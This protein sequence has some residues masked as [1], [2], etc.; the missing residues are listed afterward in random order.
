MSFWFIEHGNTNQRFTCI[1][2]ALEIEELGTR[3]L[4]EAMF[5][6]RSRINCRA[7]DHRSTRST[8]NN[9]S[10]VITCIYL[11]IGRP[12]SLK[13]DMPI[14]FYFP[15]HSKSSTPCI[16]FAPRLLR[17]YYVSIDA[18][19]K[20]NRIWTSSRAPCSTR[21]IY[22]FRLKF[23]NRQATS[24]GVNQSSQSFQSSLT[25]FSGKMISLTAPTKNDW[26]QSS[27]MN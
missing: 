7:G 5:E 13:I 16:F 10:N 8:G 22:I 1:S 17:W 21:L 27:E 6:N 3:G 15:G 26:S 25:A 24:W 19:Q 11:H 23:S 18:G 2:K 14:S 9:T 12:S 4:F 20:Q